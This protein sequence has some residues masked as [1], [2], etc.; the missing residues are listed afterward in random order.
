[1]SKINRI[2]PN[3]EH[4]ET[5][6]HLEAKGILHREK[7]GIRHVIRAT[8]NTVDRVGFNLSDLYGPVWAPSFPNFYPGTVFVSGWVG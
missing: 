8:T 7:V 1:M 6:K 3:R 5:L 4:R 2:N